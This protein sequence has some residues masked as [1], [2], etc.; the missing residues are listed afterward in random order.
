MPPEATRKQLLPLLR[1]LGC[2][3]DIPKPRKG[4]ANLGYTNIEQPLN[5][6]LRRESLKDGPPSDNRGISLSGLTARYL[7]HK[8][9]PERQKLYDEGYPLRPKPLSMGLRAREYLDERNSDVFDVALWSYVLL[10]RSGP[11]AIGRLAW[12]C[13]KVNYRVPSF[14]VNHNLRHISGHTSITVKA[15]IVLV[16][17]Y[18]TRNIEIAE[19][20]GKPNLK[21]DPV[22][23]RIIFLRLFRLANY[24][25]P[26]QLSDVAEIYAKHSID[27]PAEIT[28]HD[29][30]FCNHILWAIGGP[31]RIPAPYYASLRYIIDA[32]V[33]LL[34]KMFKANPVMHLDPKG[35]RGIVRTRL[36]AP[37]T[38]RER[39]MIGQQGFNWPPWKEIHDGYDQSHSKIDSDSEEMVVSDAGLVLTE[40]QRAGYPLKAWDEAAMILAGREADGTPTVPRRTWFIPGGSGD[41]NPFTAW[42]ARVRATR[43]INEAWHIFLKFLNIQL[44]THEERSAA[45]HVFQEMFLK[46]IQARKQDWEN[47]YRIAEEISPYVPAPKEGYKRFMP[48]SQELDKLYAPPERRRDPT[49]DYL[50]SQNTTLR[51]PTD[52]NRGPNL[53]DRGTVNIGDS[54]NLI[55]PPSDPAR[56]AYIPTPPPS[57]EELW[58]LMLRR[59]I[60]PSLALTR[61]LV[62]NSA[63]IHEAHNY[64]EEWYRYPSR[65]KSFRTQTVGITWVWWKI[66]HRKELEKLQIRQFGVHHNIMDTDSQ[67]NEAHRN[68]SDNDA[69]IEASSAVIELA[70][71]YITSLTNTTFAPRKSH[72]FDDHLTFGKKLLFGR[73][74]HAIILASSFRITN[75]SAWTAILKALNY[76][77]HHR[78]L[79][80]SSWGKTASGRL[81]SARFGEG[82]PNRRMRYRDVNVCVIKVWEYVRGFWGYPQD[83]GFVYEL[84]IA[85][86][87]GWDYEQMLKRNRTMGTGGGYSGDGANRFKPLPWRAQHAIEVFESAV[88]I[89][90]VEIKNF[91]NPGDRSNARGVG[92]DK[93]RVGPRENKEEGDAAVAAMADA[94]TGGDDGLFARLVELS[95]PMESTKSRLPPMVVPRTAHLHAYMRLLLKTRW[96]EFDPVL[97]LLKWMV[98]YKDFLEV[99]NRRLPIIALRALWDF[100]AGID[101]DITHEGLKLQEMRGNNYEQAKNVVAKGLKEWGGWATEMEVAA[102]N[103]ENW[104]DL[105]ETE[106]SDL[107]DDIEED[108]EEETEEEGGEES[109]SDEEGI[110]E[111]NSG[112]NDPSQKS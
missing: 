2:A 49:D 100:D 50:R 67:T 15:V 86:E 55:P 83:M 108:W 64:L 22:T 41:G 51:G 87:K 103:G 43:T 69:T 1:L 62:A 60:Q 59:A 36:A 26:K 18:L 48:T 63:S 29:V 40:M 53:E 93:A 35:F 90:A 13:E 89:R 7:V 14:L 111:G 72:S 31:P 104:R 75:L 110:D 38:V 52:I 24:F 92:L 97:R 37:R 96:G 44:K 109:S 102:Y 6:A 27:H 105:R 58:Q 23:K 16:D 46:A 5:R 28:K 82:D 19:Y 98:R 11:E 57:V 94:A 74:P 106:D 21:V 77:R 3:D 95:A 8:V 25:A 81:A 79:F 76:T 45:V 85:A 88:G 66:L 71:A 99:K 32:Q 33:Y 80:Q 4:T 65:R 70:I 42:Q 10:A 101:D 68:P 73:I 12:L 56:G 9:W 78:G 30:V 112:P 39:S 47:K 54:K 84:V 20:L 107:K 91:K 17:R 34:R 61:L